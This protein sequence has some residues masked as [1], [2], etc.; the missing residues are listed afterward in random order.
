[1][2]KDVEYI[3]KTLI[4]EGALPSASSDDEDTTEAH[5]VEKVE[6]TALGVEET[7]DGEPPEK[8]KK[9]EYKTKENTNDSLPD[10]FQHI[11]ESERKVKPEFYQT[12]AA[13]TGSGLSIPEA[14]SAIVT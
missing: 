4:E 11:R 14:A 10:K 7:E 8:K 13:L 6:E 9:K 3:K 1:M 12:C 2:Y 5:E